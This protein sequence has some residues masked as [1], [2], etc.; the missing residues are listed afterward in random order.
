MANMKREKLKA[1]QLS[2]AKQKLLQFS[3]CTS[4]S[5]KKVLDDHSK[6]YL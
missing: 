3:K 4:G 2:L 5:G 6:Y 1:N